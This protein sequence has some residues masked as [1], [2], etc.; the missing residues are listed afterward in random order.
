MKN[1]VD[2]TAGDIRID[3]GT[4][5]G[6]DKAQNGVPV[7]NI[8]APSGFGVSKNTFIDFNV[9]REGIVL[10]N[11]T[12]KLGGALYANPNL[13]PNGP[14]AT[15]ILNEVTSTKGSKLYGP[16]EI[17][18]GKADYILANPN[19][20]ACD[21]CGFI[22]TPRVSLIT[23]SSRID[24]GRIEGFDI[25]K[26]G[27]VELE[28]DINVWDDDILNN[29]DEFD[30]V[31]RVAKINA[32]LYANNL[33]IK[34]GNNY[35]NYDTGEINSIELED[36]PLL[37]IDTSMIGG[38]YAG[39]ITM[40]SSEEGVGVNLGGE[41]ILD[42]DMIIT[43]EGDIVYQNITSKEGV[44]ELRASEDIT[45]KGHISASDKIDIE[46][47]GDI[48]LNCDCEEL[49]GNCVYAVNSI[50]IK[51]DNIRNNTGILSLKNRLRA[52]SRIINT[53]EIN[54]SKGI[55]IDGDKVLNRGEITSLSDIEITSRDVRNVGEIVS[56]GEINISQ[57]GS[58][59]ELIR[60]TGEII[61]KEDITI[62]TLEL[63][64]NDGVISSNQSIDIK[65]EELLRNNRGSIQ[66]LKEINVHN[67]GSGELINLL[68]EIKSGGKIYMEGHY[69]ENLG[70][71][72]G[73]GDVEILFGELI[74]RNGSIVS[75]EG[76]G[77]NRR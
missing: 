9:G 5:T 13:S 8:S 70:K 45:Q 56:E 72:Y 11:S 31:T 7:V 59:S 66:G 10:N 21:G 38:M 37:S 18:G 36:K 52:E 54:G 1:K 57:G 47:Q 67:E 44:I 32:K 22:N 40:E 39:R 15:I 71:I 51:G 33:N 53:G 14:V 62:D 30:I 26:Q 6:L 75:K 23:G 64:N 4:T 3:G 43:S 16:T 58:K 29:V 50:E 25:S 12:S 68:G 27:K 61:S 74:N 46:A 34:T 60:N 17:H 63:N 35:Y 77:L 76:I 24:K 49:E 28:G 55:D 20:I 48:L 65:Y 69:I 42:R 73:E 2:T 19:G 41:V